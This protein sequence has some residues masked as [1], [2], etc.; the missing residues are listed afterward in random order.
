MCVL[1]YDKIITTRFIFSFEPNLL[2][3]HSLTIIELAIYTCFG[4]LYY[5]KASCISRLWRP[6]KKSDIVLWNL[7]KSNEKANMKIL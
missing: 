4:L 1:S 2:K 6:G 3:I 5:P 7:A